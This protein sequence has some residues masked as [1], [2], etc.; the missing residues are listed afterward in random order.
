VRELRI[1]EIDGRTL[2]EA[3]LPTAPAG[4]TGPVAARAGFPSMYDIIGSGPP[5]RQQIKQ[6]PCSSRQ[7]FVEGRAIPYA[8]RRPTFVLFKS[9]YISPEG[10]G[11]DQFCA[12]SDL[13][14]MPGAHDLDAVSCGQTR[15]GTVV[16]NE[17]ARQLAPGDDGDG[18]GLAE[19]LSRPVSRTG[20]L[21]AQ[22]ANV[23]MLSRVG[24]ERLAEDVYRTVQRR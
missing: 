1:L 22:D 21:I 8:G 17:E 2:P 15:S 9:Q 12:A 10:V 4:T 13:E 24:K 16:G 11:V 19:M 14:E 7:P 6:T 23:L 18:L 20:K 3:T 5:I